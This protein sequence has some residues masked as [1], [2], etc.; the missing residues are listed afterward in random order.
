[1]S[2]QPTPK[3]AETLGHIRGFIE[4]NGYSPTVIE[5]AAIAGIRG[6]A[7][8]GRIDALLRKSLIT[9]TTGAART[10]RPAD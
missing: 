4:A 2:S 3:Q 1:M 10:I 6:N 5:L 8:Q 7:V 9:R